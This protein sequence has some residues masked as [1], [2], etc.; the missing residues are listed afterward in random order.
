MKVRSNEITAFIGPSGCG[1]STALR[2]FN[3][4]ND[5]VPSGSGRGHDPLPR[6]GSL[7]PRRRPDRGPA[8][9]GHGVPEAQPVPQ[10]D[11]R[12]H[13][14][15]AAGQR[16]EAEEVRGEGHGRGGPDPGRALGARSS[17]SWA[18]SGF[19]LSGGQQQRLCIARAIA[20]KPEILLMD[21]PCASLDP[22]ATALI[23]DLMQ[24]LVA[25]L[26]GGHRHPQHAAGRS[27]L[28]PTGVLHRRGRGGRQPGTAPWWRW[29]TRPRSSPTR[30]T[31]A[32][33]TTSPAASADRPAHLG[34]RPTDRVG[35]ELIVFVEIRRDPFGRP[36]DRTCRGASVVDRGQVVLL[37]GDRADRLVGGAVDPGAVEHEE[38]A[39]GDAVQELRPPGG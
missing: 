25:R 4:T 13:R 38:A 36:A 21:E 8:P 19:A 22:I 16:L 29:T 9:G 26:H 14:L 7:R 39:R 30:R 6:P 15:R 5:L 35:F 17:T 23:E 2:C 24:E 12:Q 18:Q 10:V 37:G 31:P 1:K 3:R 11:L 33:R 32:R 34:A 28:G 20:N 27:G